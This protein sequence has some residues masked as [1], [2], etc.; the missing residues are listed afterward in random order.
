[1]KAEARPLALLRDAE[2]RIDRGERPAFE[3]STTVGGM[4][5]FLAHCQVCDRWYT[6]S[7][8]G[9]PCPFCDGAAPRSAVGADGATREPARIRVQA[10]QRRRVLRVALWLLL[11]AAAGALCVFW[12][13]GWIGPARN[14]YDIPGSPG[15]PVRS[16]AQ[17]EMFR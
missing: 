5:V 17:E 9:R 10:R 1:M 15:V 4:R 3:A 7:E 11:A 13:A 8:S 16:G 12:L 6:R 2:R 14:V